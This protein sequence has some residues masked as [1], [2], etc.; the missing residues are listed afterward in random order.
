M[1]PGLFFF[2][3]SY[4]LSF[5][6][7]FSKLVNDLKYI[8]FFFCYSTLCNRFYRNSLTIYVCI[9]V[10]Y[11]LWCSDTYV[12]IHILHT[13]PIYSLLWYVSSFFSWF[14]GPPWYCNEVWQILIYFLAHFLFGTWPAHCT[15]FSMVFFHFDIIRS[16]QEYAKMYCEYITQ[17]EDTVTALEISE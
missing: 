10:F 14:R 4:F 3:L 13:L 15:C 1:L 11:S 12:L 8:Y 7:F 6:F 9:F 16:W 5:L 17:F 2:L